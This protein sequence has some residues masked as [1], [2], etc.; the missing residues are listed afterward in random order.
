M[1]SYFNTYPENPRMGLRESINAMLHHVAD[2]S[3]PFGYLP[4]ALHQSNFERLLEDFAPL[5]Q[6]SNDD[7]LELSPRVED[8]ALLAYLVDTLIS[9]CNDY[10]AYDDEHLMKIELTR[11]IETLE[12]VREEN[13]PSSE[14]IARAL[15][16]IGA[17][18]EQS[19]YGAN[20]SEADYVNA[21][22]YVQRE[23]AENLARENGQTELFIIA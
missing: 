21:I 20:V 13:H 7:S 3:R 18:V 22:E 10:P 1:N 17:Y 9:L 4:S 5:V 14:D 23:E 16:E 12:E 2:N 19:E 15:F 11:L 6:V 8:S